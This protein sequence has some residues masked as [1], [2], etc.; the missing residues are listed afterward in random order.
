[1]RQTLLARGIHRPI[2]RS[3]SASNVIFAPA[4][5]PVFES[6]MKIPTELNELNKYSTVRNVKTPI[7]NTPTVALNVTFN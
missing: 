2:T 6:G 3:I 5:L 7:Q 1:M 4:Y